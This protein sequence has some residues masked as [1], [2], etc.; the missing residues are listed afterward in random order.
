MWMGR[1]LENY[2]LKAR[3]DKGGARYEIV[4]IIELNN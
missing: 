4:C 3:I 2:P 1:S